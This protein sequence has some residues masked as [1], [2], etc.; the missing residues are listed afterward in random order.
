MT[1][2][3]FTDP[4]FVGNDMCI[5]EACDLQGVCASAKISLVVTPAES[6]VEVSEPQAVNDAL[7]IS[8]GTGM[9]SYNVLENDIPTTTGGILFVDSILYNANHG[10]CAVQDG[11]VVTYQ[12]NAGYVGQDNCVYRACEE[13][14]GCDSAV[15]AITVEPAP[16][17]EPTTLTCETNSNERVIVNPLS[18]D[19]TLVSDANYGACSIT[20]QSTVMYTPDPG[21]A[22]YD[23]VCLSMKFHDCFHFCTIRSPNKFAS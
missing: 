11:T 5:Y 15:L 20:E 1:F 4:D 3:L 9:V 22:G 10:S 16:P 6:S 7:V 23:T 14:G 18:N 12:A 13:N 21:F 19:V 17:A 8:S 2:A